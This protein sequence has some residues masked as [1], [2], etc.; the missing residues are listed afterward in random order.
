MFLGGLECDM[1]W[2]INEGLAG[3]VDH[4]LESLEFDYCVNKFR[5]VSI[6]VGKALWVQ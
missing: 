4:V 6:A 3:V 5:D 2:V 1:Q